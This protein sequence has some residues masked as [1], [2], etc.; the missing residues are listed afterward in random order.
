MLADEAKEAVLVITHSLRVL[1]GACLKCL[2]NLPTHLNT[3]TSLPLLLF[4]KNNT[5][6]ISVIIYEA[7]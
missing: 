5:S 4:V 6:V 1:L 3:C 2:M 7:E